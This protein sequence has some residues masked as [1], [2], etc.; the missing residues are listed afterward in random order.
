[1]AYVL[2]AYLLWGFFPAF[3]PLLLPA[4]P[5]EILAHRIVWCALLMAVV[6]TV[7]RNWASLRRTSRGEKLRLAAAGVLISANWGIYVLAVNTGNV[8]D[9]A[10]GYFINPLLSIALGMLVLKE[11]LRRGQLVAVVIAFVGVVWLTFLTGQPPVMALGMAVTFALY[12]LLKKRVTV[13]AATSLTA[14]TLV[15]VP[16]AAGFLVYLSSTGSSTFTT[17]GP[18]HAVLL[19]LA[20]VI[21]AAPLFF[22]GAGVKQ[23]PL[24]TLG[25]LQY[26]TPT[27]QMLWAVGVMGEQQSP[28]RWV[29]FGIIWVAVAVYLADLWQL[30]RRRV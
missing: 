20:G 19:V 24:S 16:L 18:G 28:A 15:M 27:M 4:G 17:E 1:M 7:M 14:E 25:M 26:L 30:R 8:A 5:V 6:T 12:G 3:F 10:L 11:S 2:L 13:P 21:T 9:A 23:I 22:F 29:G